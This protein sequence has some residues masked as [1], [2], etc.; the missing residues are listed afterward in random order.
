M[1]I[2]ANQSEMVTLLLAAERHSSEL[3][4]EQVGGSSAVQELFPVVV[5]A[6]F[7]LRGPVGRAA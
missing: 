7:S 1:A 5:L 2:I 4:S 6:C 3:L